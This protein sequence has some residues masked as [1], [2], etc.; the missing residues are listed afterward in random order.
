MNFSPKMQSR[1]RGFVVVGELQWRMWDGVVADLWEVSCADNASGDYISPDPRLFVMLD[2]NAG[3]SFAL[4]GNGVDRTHHNVS[5]LMSFVPSEYPVHGEALGLTRITHLDLHF[6]EAA[7]TRR[8][9]KALDRTR[10]ARPRLGLN[11]TRIASFARAIAVECS[12]PFAM[13]DLYGQALVDAL[14]SLLFDVRRDTE[15]RRPGLSRQQLAIVTDFIEANCF[16]TIR[17]SDLANLARLSETYFSHA[18][19]ASTGQP[20]HRWQMQARIR[21]V[22]ALLLKDDANLSEIATASGFADQAHFT[23]VFKSIVGLTP[24]EWRRGVAASK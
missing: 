16:G 22:Q 19:K 7:I 15:R 2:L 3:G 5:G 13:H 12:N 24:A 9:G 6:S 8:F 18:F 21:K 17:L 20:P 11:D 10:L 23:R 14:L 4:S 1:V